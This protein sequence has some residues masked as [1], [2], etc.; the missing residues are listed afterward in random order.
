MIRNG[1]DPL[2]PVD[3]LAIM[4]LVEV[5]RHIPRVRRL[6][7]RTARAIE[8]MRPDVVVTI[9]S[10]AFT[11]RVARKIKHLGIP[12]IH[13]VAP[14]VWAWRP[15]RAK[16]FARTFDHLITTLP[17]EP[18]Y[19]ERHGLSCS[20]VG[21]P[22]IERALGGNG[23]AF[24]KAHQ[25]QKGDILL[26]AM[27]GSRKSE[28][29]RLMP[30]FEQTIAL[31]SKEIPSLKVAMPIVPNVATLVR[32]QVRT[33][34]M[35]VILVEEPEDRRNLFAAADLAL[36]KSGT[37]AVELAAA[38]VPT[39]ITQKLSYL[40]VLIFLML[41]KVRFVSII[42]LMADE[43]L[44][45]ERLQT[46]CTPNALAKALMELLADQKATASRVEKAYRMAM[47][48]GAEGVPPSVKAAHAVLTFLSRRVNSAN[49]AA[50]A[51]PDCGKGGSPARPQ[52]I[53]A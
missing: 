21:Y 40:S 4:G 34:T 13:Y 51:G 46:S 43:E 14:T 48:L 44:Q 1:L 41:A 15:G 22:A 33:W 25:V 39:V 29:R 42:N 50:L 26:C 8:E 49:A 27:P 7:E 16:T 12:V 38:K 30:I 28:V 47:E 36:A 23:A 19:F 3:E 6:I 10:P 2:F 31:L 24:R 53:H 32:N 45:L 5:L 18:P 52:A 37:S 17:F 9:D 35:P 11:K 20:Y